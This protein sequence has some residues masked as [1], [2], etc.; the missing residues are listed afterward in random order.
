MRTLFTEEHDIFRRSLRKFVEKEIVPFV[1]EWEEKKYFPDEL[2]LKMGEQG[3]LGAIVPEEAGG[4]GGDYIYGAI[5]SEELA[6]SGSGG[7]EAGLGMHSLVVMNSLIKYAD[8]EQRERFL[9]PAIKGEKIGALGITEP[10]AGSDVFNI[11]TKAEKKDGYYLLNGSKIFITNGIRADFVIVLAKTD[12]SQGYGGF[13]MFFVEKG[14]EGFVASKKIDKVGWWASDT[15]ELSFSDVKVP[16]ENVL[17]NEGEG[18]YQTM[19]N[20]EWERLVM[21]LGS[22]AASRLALEKG[23]EYGKERKAFGRPIGKFQVWKHRF[24][25]YYSLL[26]AA[27]QLTYH[28]LELFNNGEQCLKEVT[29]AKYVSTELANKI[30]DM[31]LQFFG[32]YGY[33]MEYPLQRFWRDA[34]IGTIGGGTSEIMLEIISKMI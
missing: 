23:L 33:S 5:V 25:E 3:F 8:N 27:T 26:E 28:G 29:M 11:K 2:F 10:N 18:F 16:F 21:A 31:V 24:A 12:E 6:R 17:G 32:G 14:M 7:V 22:N 19:S 20:F 34:R 15:A 13:T 4:F 1:D 30:S 9:I